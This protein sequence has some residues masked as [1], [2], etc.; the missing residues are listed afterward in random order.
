[1]VMTLVSWRP[2]HWDVMDVKLLI[3]W[4]SQ[5]QHNSARFN[6]VHFYANTNIWQLV[7]GIVWTRRSHTQCGC[8]TNVSV[9]CSF[10]RIYILYETHV[11]KPKPYLR[12]HRHLVASDSGTLCIFHIHYTI[13]VIYSG[14]TWGFEIPSSRSNRTTRWLCCVEI[15]T[16]R[17]KPKRLSLYHS[18]TLFLSLSHS[19]CDTKAHNIS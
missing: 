16:D 18:L 9:Q 4:L 10:R 2:L 6:R 8:C 15:R 7:S 11:F 14:H 17:G 3:V 5:V 1:M 13:Q 19:G 12:D